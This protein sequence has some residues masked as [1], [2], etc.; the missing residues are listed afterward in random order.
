MG[1]VIALLLAAFGLEAKNT[2]VNLNKM[3]ETKSLQQSVLTRDD[4]G[5]LV[6]KRD[7]VGNF[8]LENCQKDLYN[9]SNF[10]TQKEALEVFQKCG[11]KGDD[12]NGLDGD[13]DGKPCEELPIGK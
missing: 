7:A 9:C 12:V 8:L 13:K 4:K 6:F 10:K 11:G 2:D 5:N 3:V 1:V